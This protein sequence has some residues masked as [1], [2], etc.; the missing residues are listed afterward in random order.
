[1]NKPSLHNLVQRAEQ[2]EPDTRAFIRRMKK[3]KKQQLDE[4]VH[5]LHEEAFSK[6]SCLDCA[7]C[8]RH[9]SPIV[10]E[11]DI[12]RI[13][14]HLRMKPAAFTSRYL[15]VDEE[16]DY[17]FRQSPCPFLMPDNCCSIYPKRPRSCRDYPHTNRKN[18]HHILE[19]SIRDTYI[20]PVVFEIIEKL[21]DIYR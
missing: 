8:C 15:K 3:K 13:A 5:Q 21:K 17:V 14:R 10:Y 2:A 20:C 6:F 19:L 18:F 7:N 16:D 1:M 11:K 9:I 4:L 12:D